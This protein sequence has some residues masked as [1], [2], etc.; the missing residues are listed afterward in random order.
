MELLTNLNS[1]R[2]ELLAAL[3]LAYFCGAFTTTV[4]A[5]VISRHH[6]RRR[7]QRLA[8]LLAKREAR[9]RRD[10]PH[11][12]DYESNSVRKSCGK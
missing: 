5:L 7:K 12:K 11:E 9:R 6:E 3:T 8:S 1:C 10:V 4:I 2:A